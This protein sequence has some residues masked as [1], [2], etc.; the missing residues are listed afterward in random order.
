MIVIVPC[1]KKK[2][3]EPCLARDMYEGEYHKKAQ[4]I[5]KYLTAE[6]EIFILSAKYGFLPLDQ[7]IEPYNIKAG[8]RGSISRRE[9]LYQAMKLDIKEKEAVILGGQIYQNLC[10]LVFSRLYAP[11]PKEGIGKQL[12]FMKRW[13]AALETEVEDAKTWFL[14]RELKSNPKWRLVDGQV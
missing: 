1:G 11:L 4:E 12:Q 5:A 2:S 6:D 3:E 7:F 10:K 13:I 14:N 9:L 8:E